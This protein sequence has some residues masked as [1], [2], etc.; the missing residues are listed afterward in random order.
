MHRDWSNPAFR[1]VGTTDILGHIIICCGDRPAHR[2]TFHSIPGLHPLDAS[3]IPPVVKTK[4]V[5]GHCQMS[6][7][8]QTPPPPS[9][10][11]NCCSGGGRFKWTATLFPIVS[12]R[13]KGGHPKR[14]LLHP[15]ERNRCDS[16]LQPGALIIFVQS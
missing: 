8:A 13:L 2:R 5:P 15:A 4:N 12:G 10:H 14:R 3:S 6:L 1:S 11:E 9:V 16:C 7:G